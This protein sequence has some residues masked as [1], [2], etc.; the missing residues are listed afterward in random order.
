MQ[1]SH[2]HETCRIG[3]GSSTFG[4]EIDRTA[5]FAVLDHAMAHGITFLDTAALY[6][7]GE[8]ERIIGAWLAE[9]RPAPGEVFLATKIYPPF[10]EAAMT[11]AFEGSLQR[12]G[13][14]SI[15][16][17]YLHKWDDS[18][19]KAEA[20]QTLDSFIRNGR[21][22]AIGASNFTAEQFAATWRLQESLAVA[23]FGFLQNNHS[24]AVRGVDAAVRAFCA[25]HAISIVTYSPLGAGFLTGKHRRGVESG[26]RFEVSPGHRD[27][28][29]H[30]ACW[31]RLDVLEKTAARTGI[32]QVK[33]ALAW[34]FHQQG[35]DRVLIGCRR[36]GHIEQALAAIAF[37]DPALFAE[38]ESA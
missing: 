16:L 19:A 23:R 22:R 10:T 9:R 14:D 32:S 7:A 34:V 20:V 26:S 11:A 4:R 27:I 15:D 37:N 35:I 24:L 6:S 5:A 31:H 29:F 1:N 30:D 17:L 8:S 2:S 28:Y 36:P 25:Q 38:L 21:T 33:L 3:L 13:V 12:L 18:A